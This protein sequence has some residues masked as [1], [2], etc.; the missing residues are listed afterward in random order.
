MGEF[1]HRVTVEPFSRFLEGIIEF[2]PNLLSAIL[3]LAAGIAVSV[4]LKAVLLRAFRI[5]GLDRLLEHFGMVEVLRKGGV[6]ESLSQLVSRFVAWVTFMV[7]IIISLYA[8]NL[9]A[10]EQVLGRFILYLPNV[11]VA[12]IVMFFGYLLSNFMGRAALIAAVNAGSKISGII[13]KG[14]KFTVFIL[15]ATMALEQLGIS[16]GTVIITFAII[17]GGMVLALALSFGLGGKEIAESYL[18]KK[19]KGEDKEDVIRHL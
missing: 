8:L 3:I 9:P 18:E 5:L 15:A 10:V 12:A 1:L 6:K 4:L 11:F 7:F 17:F 13:G 2:L 19:L 16:R 14:V